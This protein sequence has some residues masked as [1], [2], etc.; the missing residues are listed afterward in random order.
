VVKWLAIGLGGALGALARTVVYQ[1]LAYRDGGMPWATV[2][3]NLS[4]AFALGVVI[5]MGVR[6]PGWDLVVFGVGIGFLGAFTTFSTFGLE[7]VR[8]L[9]RNELG[10]ALV[11]VL[12]NVVGAVTAAAL[13]VLLARRL[14]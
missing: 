7:T 8:L 5:E 12:L 11:S 4:G 3:V 10:V 9:Q 2:L 1:L 6:R 13:G 14:L